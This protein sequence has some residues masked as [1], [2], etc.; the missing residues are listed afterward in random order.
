MWLR[1]GCNEI[2]SY[3]HGTE[4]SGLMRKGGG[5]ILL[6]TLGLLASEPEELYSSRSKRAK[7][8]SFQVFATSPSWS[9]SSS[10]KEDKLGTACP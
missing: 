10:G 1:I 7:N 9:F 8:S 5:G 2:L 6:Q 3:K 4:R